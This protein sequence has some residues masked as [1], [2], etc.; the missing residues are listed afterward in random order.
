MCCPSVTLRP[1]R[2]PRRAPVRPAHLCRGRGG[3]GCRCHQRDRGLAARA[4]VTLRA[5]DADLL[6]VLQPAE[7]AADPPGRPQAPPFRLFGSDETWNREGLS[8]HN[9]D[10]SNSS[11]R[12]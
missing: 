8:W 2:R 1:A 11:L 10:R 4:P 7:A 3:R 9:H 5:R 12:A 6:P